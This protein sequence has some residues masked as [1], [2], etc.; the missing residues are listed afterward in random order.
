MAWIGTP[1]AWEAA[2]RD[3]ITVERGVLI[4][5]AAALAAYLGAMRV[6]EA[7]FDRE[8]VMARI[9][10]A[11]L[12]AHPAYAELHALLNPAPADSLVQ[13]FVEGLRRAEEA[14]AKGIAALPP[15][16]CHTC[17]GEGYL[18]SIASQMLSDCPDCV[19]GRTDGVI[20]SSNPQ[21]ENTK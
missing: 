4:R 1:M 7:S 2:M 9:R 21:P 15:G 13:E 19:G 14:R 6:E 3:P 10:A 5:A 8:T 18:G 17:M 12:M 11:D 16:T 20:P